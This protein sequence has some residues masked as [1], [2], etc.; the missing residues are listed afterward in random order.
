MIK[1]Y[2]FEITIDGQRFAGNIPAKS[3]E[4]AQELVPTADMIGELVER[5]EMAQCAICR[6]DI[7]TE[8]VAEPVWADIITE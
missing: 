3:F 4:H 5:V 1:I 2:C 6:G 8:P 7:V